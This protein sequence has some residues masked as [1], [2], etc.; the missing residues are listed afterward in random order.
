MLVSESK[1]TFVPFLLI[2]QHF[3][4]L[5]AE[6]KAQTGVSWPPCPQLEGGGPRAQPWRRGSARRP[7]RLG[8]PR[9]GCQLR[10]QITLAWRLYYQSRHSFRLTCAPSCGH[11]VQLS[12]IKE[13]HWH[14]RHST[15]IQGVNFYYQWKKVVKRLWTFPKRND[16]MFFFFLMYLSLYFFSHHYNHM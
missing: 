10:V 9:Q 15:E 6:R 11:H 1:H 12:Q 7:A 16:L 13:N 14:W 8:S 4:R 2:T 5:P 3:L